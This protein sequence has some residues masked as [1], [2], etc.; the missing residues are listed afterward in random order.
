MVVIHKSLSKLHNAHKMFLSH[1]ENQVRTIL[2]IVILSPVLGLIWWEYHKNIKTCPTNFII[3]RRFTNNLDPSFDVFCN[4][5]LLVSEWILSWPFEH[6][7][8]STSH[9]IIWR[10]LVKFEHF[11][12]S[13]KIFYSLR[14]GDFVTL[15]HGFFQ[16]FSSFGLPTLTQDP[17]KWRGF[18]KD[19][20][21]LNKVWS[22]TQFYSVGW[23][24]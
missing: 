23:L 5:F 19:T 12:L 3:L 4:T 6:F 9:H 1:V 2:N 8:L 18:W 10:G 14:P 15:F 13:W 24:Q 21:R 17:A 22:L 16:L 20:L 11:H 7:V